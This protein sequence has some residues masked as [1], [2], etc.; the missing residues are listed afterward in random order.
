MQEQ[1]HVLHIL[2]LLKDAI[3]EYPSPDVPR[4]PAFTTLLLAHAL[5][6]VFHPSTF[7]YPLTA[8]FLLQRPQLDTS[9]VPLL[10][11]LLYSASA[12]WKAERGWVLRFLSAAGA[13]ADAWRALRRR[14]TWDLLA[15][16]FQGDARDR[17]LRRGVLE[18][19]ASV[20][21]RP[22]AATAL[23]LR[24]ALLAWVEMQLRSGGAEEPLAWVK[25][26]ANVVAVV[27]PAK[28]EAATNGEWRLCLGRCLRAI[29]TSPGK[30]FMDKDVS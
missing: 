29:L 24:S 20:T 12:Q 25:I 18:V 22:R 19:L 3:A 16:L 11:S 5:R 7:T 27:D 23:V 4:L 6:G 14:H 30:S 10:F 28:V 9:D 8:R 15:S 2:N 21:C 13:G 1:P 17:A 26:L